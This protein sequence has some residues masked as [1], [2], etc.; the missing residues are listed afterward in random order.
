MAADMDEVGSQLDAHREQVRLHCYRMTGS[1]QDAEDLTQE[2]L[3]RAWQKRS[4]FRGDSSL[5]TWL[6]RIATN[7]CLDFL[8]GRKGRVL[9]L[10]S[11]FPRYQTGNDLPR[12][13]PEALW[14]E[15][16]P[17]PEDE[18]LRREHISL[19]FLTLLQT[20]PPKQRAALLLVDVL[21]Y[22]VKETAETLDM[23]SVAVNSALQRARK[24]LG[25]KTIPAEVDPRDRK[26][27]LD[28]FL[29]AWDA[30]DAT[31]IVAL[32]RVDTRMVMPPIPLWV[33]GPSDILRVLIDFPFRWGDPKRWKLVSVSGA[34]GEP[35]VGFYKLDLQAHVYR[36]WGVQVL[37]L[38]PAQDGLPVVTEYFVFKGTTLVGKFGLPEILPG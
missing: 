38:G 22:S 34:N 13:L 23:T 6:Y 10:G 11:E 31:A 9:L 33:Q 35:A 21:G 27:I 28:R 26:E 18:T 8:R 7:A 32:M 14:L 30:G 37:V 4:T 25:P 1:L 15:P 20:L 19:A 5:G 16:Y 29:A 24:T 17:D 3:V 2:T 36:P 12:A